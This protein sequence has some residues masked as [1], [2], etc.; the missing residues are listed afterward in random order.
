MAQAQQLP[1]VNTPD[2][3]HTPAHLWIGRH[4]DLVDRVTEFLQDQLC[5]TGTKACQTCSTCMN[6]R[7][8]QHHATTW[9]APEKS[10][11]LAHL[12][13]IFKTITFSLEADA[14]HFFILQKADFLTPSCANSLLK[15]LE[16]P[17]TGYHFMLMAERP[18]LI[19]PTIRSRCIMQQFHTGSHTSEHKE[20][21][22]FFT[23]HANTDPAA[24][25]KAVDAARLNEQQSIELVDYLLAYWLKEYTNAIKD[26]KKDLQD[27]AKHAVDT[28]STLLAKPLMP[29]SSKL[30]WKE[31]SLRINSASI[32]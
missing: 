7:D 31:L 16:E 21:L 22:S 19:L 14:Q 6:I 13:V 26:G 15:S 3:T 20:L 10:Y 12:E 8:H 27:Q 24:F 17:P 18:E 5:T 29:G 30:F 11:T 23:R 4:D 2:Y 9:I 32:T 25:L 28:L 1:R